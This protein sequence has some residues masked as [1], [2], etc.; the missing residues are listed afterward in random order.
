MIQAHPSAFALPNFLA[1]YYDSEKGPFRSLTHLH[2]KEAEA[3]QEA[4]RKEGH[5]FASR[6]APDY[7]SVRR[8]LEERIR[9]LLV[10]K[11]GRP[12]RE[13]PH[14]MILGTCPWV[15]TWYAHGCEARIPLTQFHPA[16]LSFTYGDSFPAMRWMD[17]RPYRGQVY[18]LEELSAVVQR[19]GLPQ[20]WNAD[21]QGGPERYIE[22]QIWED[23]PIQAFLADSGQSGH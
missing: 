22:A 17:G 16:C 1:H 10:A 13:R 3:I 19:W 8:S 2:E 11:G 20:D 6:R 18:T 21:G 15:K 5:G 4:L 23:G 12:Q 9:A 14:Y 7:L